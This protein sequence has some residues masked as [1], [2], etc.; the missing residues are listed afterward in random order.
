MNATYNNRTYYAI[1]PSTFKKLQA[2]IVNEGELVRGTY[3]FANTR[4]VMTEIPS[5]YQSFFEKA[6]ASIKEVGDLVKAIT[7]GD[8]NHITEIYDSKHYTFLLKEIYGAFKHF[9]DDSYQT[10]R[11]VIAF[12]ASHCFDS[13][14]V[15]LRDNGIIITVNMRS[16][17]AYKNLA[18][19]AFLV[20]LLVT[21]GL[22]SLL[23]KQGNVS[24]IMNIGSLH[25]FKEDVK[26][27]LRNA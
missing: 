17:N 4:I 24:M 16:C 21:F 3:E 15:L 22:R 14:Q 7:D 6:G 8:D 25:V 19:D 12:P 13:I 27:V 1:I 10:R 11:A 18:N 20:Y 2:D 26:N 9:V 5:D 23:R